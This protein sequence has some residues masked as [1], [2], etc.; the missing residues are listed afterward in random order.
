MPQWD[1]GYNTQEVNDLLAII[2][3]IKSKTIKLITKYNYLINS[4][5]NSQKF[6]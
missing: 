6:Y 3:K 1:K 4:Q 2:L 5:Y